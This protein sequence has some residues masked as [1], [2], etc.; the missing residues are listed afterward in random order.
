MRILGFKLLEGVVGL[1]RGDGVV[2]NL[3]FFIKFGFVFWN[4]GFFRIF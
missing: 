1:G 3:D 4:K 2:F